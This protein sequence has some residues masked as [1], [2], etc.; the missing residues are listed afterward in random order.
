MSANSSNVIS[1][2]LQGAGT[3]KNPLLRAAGWV[4]SN[5]GVT[6]S[7]DSTH[8]ASIATK[9]R[10]TQHCIE[11]QSVRLADRWLCE[12]MR[13]FVATG[14]EN[15]FS[16]GHEDNSVV[17]L[18]QAWRRAQLSIAEA[19]DFRWKTKLYNAILIVNREPG[20]S[21]RARQGNAATSP[22]KEGMY[23][24]QRLPD[25]LRRAFRGTHG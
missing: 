21:G 14:G 25:G 24:V 10:R 22:E 1:N 20:L 18:L 6:T 23:P 5:A 3:K 13:P 2:A 12:R 19:Q 7:V 8:P 16:S 11:R 17:L 15:R 9:R 4:Q